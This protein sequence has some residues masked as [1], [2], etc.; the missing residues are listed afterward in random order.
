[1]RRIISC[2]LFILL[3]LTGKT[4]LAQQPLP[5]LNPELPIDQRVDDLI[6]RMTLEEKAG[7][8][9]DAHIELGAAVFLKGTLVVKQ[10]RVMS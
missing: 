4:L 7:Q 5:Y 3:I 9:V 10:S 8:M 1:M 2:L 6:S